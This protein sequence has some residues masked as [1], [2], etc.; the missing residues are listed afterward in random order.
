VGH[1]PLS[2]SCVCAYVFVGPTLFLSNHGTSHQS[3]YCKHHSTETDLRYIPDQLI[4]A[5][6]S[7]KISCLCLLDLSAAF[8]TIDYS[9]L[10]RL[11][12]WFGFHGSVLNWFKSYFSSRS[13]HVKCHS[14][15]SSYRISSRGV[16]QGSVLSPILFIM[17]TTPFSTLISSLS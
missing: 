2:L 6:D 1:N 5:L 3:A 8:D 15:F 13:F 12:S 4:N 9:I 10:I 11:P 7:Q 17:Y 14:S 16:P